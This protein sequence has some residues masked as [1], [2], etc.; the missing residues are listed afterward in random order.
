MHRQ[1]AYGFMSL[2]QFNHFLIYLCYFWMIISFR[3]YMFQ[4][5]YYIKIY[6]A[7]SCLLME[8]RVSL[9]EKCLTQYGV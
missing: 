7:S 8:T 9:E 1:I 3:L 2:E 6:V 5:I 4:S